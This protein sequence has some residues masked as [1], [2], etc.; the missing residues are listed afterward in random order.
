MV[1]GS[2]GVLSN[3]IDVFRLSEVWLHF[4]ESSIVLVSSL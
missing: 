4:F 1:D 3:E 2:V